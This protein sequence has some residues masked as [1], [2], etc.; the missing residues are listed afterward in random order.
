VMT[1]VLF[2]LPLMYTVPRGRAVW[3]RHPWWLLG[4]QAVLTYLP[5]LMFGRT[6]AVGLSRRRRCGQPAQSRP[7]RRATRIASIRLRAP[8]SVTAEAR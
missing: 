1:V 5:F 7:D 2:A 3:A 8:S 6:W 4:T